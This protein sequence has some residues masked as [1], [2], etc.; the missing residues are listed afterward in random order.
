MS[1]PRKRSFKIDGH[2]TSLSLE[3]PF[4]DALQDIAAVEK[5]PVSRLI[6]DIDA[7]RGGSGLSSAV[8]VWLLAHYRARA[9]G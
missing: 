9:R 5:R 6:S 8:R 7:S 4:W 1:R 2:R 3:Q